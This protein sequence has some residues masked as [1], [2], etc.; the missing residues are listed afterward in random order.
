MTVKQLMERATGKPMKGGTVTAC[1]IEGCS[2]LVCK[3][4]IQIDGG[5][6]LFICDTHFK[7]VKQWAEKGKR[8]KAVKEAVVPVHYARVIGDGEL[9]KDE[10]LE[11]AAIALKAKS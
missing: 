9:D 10:M 11:L 1:V 5:S 6:P 2:P 4:W 7:Q 3:R 8:E